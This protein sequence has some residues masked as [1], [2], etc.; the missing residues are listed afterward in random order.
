MVK[1]VILLKSPCPSKTMGPMFIDFSNFYRKV[2]YDNLV[3]YMKS[4]GEVQAESSKSMGFWWIRR[5]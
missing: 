1:L 4:F 3:L 5:E 2:T